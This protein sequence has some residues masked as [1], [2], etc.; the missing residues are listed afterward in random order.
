MAS[1]MLSPVRS[2]VG[3]WGGGQLDTGRFSFLPPGP[4]NLRSGR[5]GQCCCGLESRTEGSPGSAETTWEWGWKV[6]VWAA[7]LGRGRAERK[8]SH[9]RAPCR[10]DDWLL[11]TPMWM[12]RTGRGWGKSHLGAFRKSWLDVSF[13]I[14]KMEAVIPWVYKSTV[15]VSPLCE[16]DPTSSSLL[17]LLIVGDVACA[18]HLLGTGL[19]LP[20]CISVGKGWRTS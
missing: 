4:L 17:W 18:R 16:S 15:K 3:V 1:S 20:S 19:W 6:W 11:L 5:E 9:L 13:L 2:A 12:S 8:P 7:Q 14:C 10:P